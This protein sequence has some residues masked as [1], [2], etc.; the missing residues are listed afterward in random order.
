[1]RKFGPSPAMG[2][3]LRSSRRRPVSA[4]CLT[5]YSVPP[6]EVR[7]LAHEGDG[8]VAIELAVEEDRSLRI[9]ELRGYPRE[10][11]KHAELVAEKVRRPAAR[12]IPMPSSAL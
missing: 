7:E 1:V 2:W 9:A 12:R 8:H 3:V 5:S 10:V 11:V 4:I 6:L